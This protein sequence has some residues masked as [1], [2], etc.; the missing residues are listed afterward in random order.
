MIF[1]AGASNPDRH[2]DNLV[3][4]TTPRCMV[5][6]EQGTLWVDMFAWQAY[7]SGRL[8]AQQA[9][10]DMSPD[11]REQIISGTH[12]ACWDALFGEE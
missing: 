7:T 8:L 10:P 3:A 9:F 12:S 5:C 1:V 2:G 4:V 11:A 6:R